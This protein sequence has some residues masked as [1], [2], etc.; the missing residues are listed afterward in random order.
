MTGKFSE[1]ATFS[2]AYGRLRGEGPCTAHEDR[3]PSEHVLHCIWFDQRFEAAALKTAEG[4]PIE[5]V[6]P[7]WWNRCE[8]PDFKGAQIAF[9]G[10]LRTG[11]VEIHFSHGAWR[12]HGHHLDPRYNDVL[13]HVVHESAPPRV[14]PH[15]ASGRP[16]A[17]LLLAPLLDQSLET[18]AQELPLADYP[19]RVRGAYGQCTRLLPEQGPEP[20]LRMLALAG[21]WR[22]L[23]KA[24]RFEERAAAA[25]PEQALYEE[26][27]RACGYARFK[28]Q[29]FEIA[30]ALPYERVAQLCDQ[31]PELAEAA[32]LRVA[33]LLPGGTNGENPAHPRLEQIDKL[34]RTALGD[35]RALPL[36][37]PRT[38]VRPANY[39][40]RRLAGM[41]R[42]V[43]RTRRH[44]LHGALMRAWRTEDD[45]RA[46]RQA[47]E[48]LFPNAMGFWGAHCTWNGKAM[49]RPSAPIGATRVRA[50][51]GNVFVPASLAHARATRDRD[52]EERVFRFFLALP[53]ETPNAVSGAMLPRLFAG[54][55]PPRMTFR[56]Q[57]GVLQLH[58]DWCAPNPSCRHCGMFEHLAR[59]DPTLAG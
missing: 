16:I 55:K 56:L 6:S 11:D 10:A 32:L 49:A 4:Q 43:Q 21:D 1:S 14:P 33:G 12:A 51:I 37:W 24:G 48:A 41:A 45:P 26:I 19:N 22:M 28:E 30:R 57:Q 59:R 35:L 58:Q 46:L 29:F 13:L 20:L 42:L 52:L 39:P 50:I 47:F 34:R 53:G 23:R 27:M 2:D 54:T 5:I 18:I 7:G 3:A 15:D 44:G 38:S 36:V 8:G 9:N 40:E 17:S 31:D 25:G